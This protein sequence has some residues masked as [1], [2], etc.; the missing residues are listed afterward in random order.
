MCT[1]SWYHYKLCTGQEKGITAL[2]KIMQGRPLVVLFYW[3]ASD[4]VMCK[5]VLTRHFY[6]LLS[7]NSAVESD[8]NVGACIARPLVQPEKLRT[9][10]GRPYY[11]PRQMLICI[12]I[13]HY[14]KHQHSLGGMKLN[15]MRVRRPHKEVFVSRTKFPQ[16]IENYIV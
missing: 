15:G 16:V 12:T 8:C 14:H 3:D 4:F 7:L 10:N 13:P 1:Y 2:N 6:E 5:R 9:T 11:T